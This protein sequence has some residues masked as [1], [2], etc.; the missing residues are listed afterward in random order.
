MNTSRWTGTAVLLLAGYSA[1][2]AAANWATTLWQAVSLAGLQIPA[3]AFFAGLAFTVRDLLQDAAGSRTSW[4]R[5]S[6]G[7]RCPA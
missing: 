6:P 1:T 7:Q 3:G 4:S 5:S 2:I